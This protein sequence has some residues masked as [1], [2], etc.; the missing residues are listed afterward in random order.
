MRVEKQ[1]DE[2]YLNTIARKL[3]WKIRTGDDFLWD[4]YPNAR[5]MEFD[6]SESNDTFHASVIFNEESLLVYEITGHGKL[7]SLMNDD[8]IWRWINI[9]Y[10]EAHLKSCIDRSINPNRAYDDINYE[11]IDEEELMR[12]LDIIEAS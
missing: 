4:C 10:I 1:M 6:D 5:I 8:T 9:D 12:R 3:K 7:F 2:L 11:N